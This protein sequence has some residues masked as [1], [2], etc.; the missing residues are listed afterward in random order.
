MENAVIYCD[1]EGINLIHCRYGYAVPK[2]SVFIG[3]T[4]AYPDFFPLLE[5]LECAD[6]I[7]SLSTVDSQTLQE[8]ISRDAK[9]KDLENRC[10]TAVPRS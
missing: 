2:I 4:R 3:M 7:Q 10:D 1:R 8:E 5:A 9:R 6:R